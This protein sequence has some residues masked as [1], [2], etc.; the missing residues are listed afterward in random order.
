MRNGVTWR[1]Y[2]LNQI[3]M[4]WNPNSIPEE[5]LPYL[6]GVS[7]DWVSKKLKGLPR[8]KADTVVSALVNYLRTPDY[9]VAIS[10]DGQQQI[11]M[12]QLVD[13]IRSEKASAEE[14]SS[15]AV[16][17]IAG[18]K[19]RSGVNPYVL[20]GVLYVDTFFKQVSYDFEDAVT[21]ALELYCW[22]CVGVASSKLKELVVFAQRIVAPTGDVTLKKGLI[23][24][25]ILMCE[26][27]QVHPEDLARYTFFIS[28]LSI[29]YR[30]LGCLAW[31]RDVS[32]DEVMVALPRKSGDAVALACLPKEEFVTLY[33][34]N[35]EKFCHA[36]A[37]R[38]RIVFGDEDV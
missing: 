15:W 37:F 16:S 32:H 9:S 21:A 26:E 25:F 27:A 12:S 29:P 36:Y 35:K 6:D 28:D 30:V 33:M 20:D 34:A 5:A 8:V 17:I 23:K 3:F 10:E 31:W 24:K 14:F 11:S 4:G 18:V 7:A 19:Y 22:G 38:D 1:Y 2:L 13:L